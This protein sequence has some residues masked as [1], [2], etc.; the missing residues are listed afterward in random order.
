MQTPKA[1]HFCAMHF[2]SI[3]ALL[4]RILQKLT[5][6]L[7][8][9]ARKRL[10]RYGTGQRHRSNER[11]ESQ[12]RPRP[13]RTLVLTWKQPD[14]QL[15]VLPDLFRGKRASPLIAARDLRCQRG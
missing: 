1:F 7:Q 8:D 15:K 4:G 6:S 10:I 13:C 12:N 3:L 11:T 2:Y 14:N 5:H 9:L